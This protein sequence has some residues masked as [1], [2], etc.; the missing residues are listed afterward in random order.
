MPFNMLLDFVGNMKR[1]SITLIVTLLMHAMFVI[2]AD[3]SLSRGSDFQTI[4]LITLWSAGSVLAVVKLRKAIQVQGIK[5]IV[6]RVGYV[7]LYLIALLPLSLGGLFIFLA[8]ALT[9]EDFR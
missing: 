2:A 8:I 4:M 5:T 9:G 6:E 1:T 7:I 3:Y